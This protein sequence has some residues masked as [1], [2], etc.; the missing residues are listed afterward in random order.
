MQAVHHP[1]HPPLLRV[2]KKRAALPSS[3]PTSDVQKN[4]GRPTINS[5]NNG[6]TQKRRRESGILKAAKAE[7]AAERELQRKLQPAA[8]AAAAAA[9][10]QKQSAPE[11]TT[12]A[13]GGSAEVVGGLSKA[14]AGSNGVSDLGQAK[15]DS[16]KR[17]ERG[18][19]KR[20]KAKGADA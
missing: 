6:N 2:G 10:Q 12:A 18:H 19:K 4:T 8:G 7:L 16:R 20:K 3:A 11:A 1:I 5:N 17:T 9:S 14:H 13:K 15:G